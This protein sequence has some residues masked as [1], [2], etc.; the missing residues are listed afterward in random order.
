MG[1]FTALGNLG[2]IAGAY[3][4]PSTE[5]PLYR[6]GHYVCFA[7]ALCAAVFA[8]GN[9]L[10]LQAINR[11]RDMEFGTVE[12]EAPDVTE[13]ADGHPMFRYIT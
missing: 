11:K 5:A 1:A 3:F 10:L 9:S 12:G 2:S 6:R 4:Y 7:M 8:L 13:L